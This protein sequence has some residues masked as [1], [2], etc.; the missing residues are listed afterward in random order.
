MANF[1]IKYRKKNDPNS[2]TYNAYFKDNMDSFSVMI[3]PEDSNLNTMWLRE[4]QFDD[5]VTN[6]ERIDNAE[7]DH[8]TSTTS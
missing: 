7:K 5:W 3:E 6:F 8:D 2:L 4:E 1:T